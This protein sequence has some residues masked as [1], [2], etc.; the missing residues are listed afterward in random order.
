MSE[1]IA[2]F[3]EVLGGAVELLPGKSALAA[4]TQQAA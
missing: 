1:C 2:L 4:A 3:L